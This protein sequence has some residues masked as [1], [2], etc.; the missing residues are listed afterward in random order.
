MNGKTGL[1]YFRAR[2]Y[3]PAF[4]RFMQPDPLNIGASVAFPQTW[5]AYNYVANNPLVNTDPFGLFCP[6]T[7]CEAPAPD[8]SPGIIIDPCWLFPGLCWS[9]PGN[10]Q[11][12]AT[13]PP[14]PLPQPVRVPA[15]EAKAANKISCNTVLPNGQTVGDVVRQQRARLLSVANDAVVTANTG[16]PSNPFGEITGA[17]YP[18]AK[19]NGPI[20]FKNNFRGQANGAMLGQA[21][22]FAYYAIG[23]GILPNWELDAG[24]GA[25]ALYSAF[26]G[27][28][29]FSSLTGPMFSDASAVSVRNVGLAAN[30]CA[31]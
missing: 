22:N 2:H 6:A 13:P 8:P 14:P 5:H 16:M 20:D 27:Q 25:Y 3:A 23:A 18:I 17:F 24:A 10:Q 26:R 11:A 1:D 4:G 31:Q 12:E 7:G 9:S 19:S 29:S 30:G 28:K 15:N 21:G